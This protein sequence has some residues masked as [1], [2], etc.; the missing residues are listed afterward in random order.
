MEIIP[1]IRDMGRTLE[2]AEEYGAVFEYDDFMLGEQI[3]QAEECRRRVDY[4]K[5][6]DRDRSMDT[7]HGLFLDV[8]VHS[9][10]RLIREVSEKRVYQSMQIAEE[11]GV[12]GVVFHSGLISNFHVKSYRSM[13]LEKN[14]AFWKRVLRDFPETRIYMENMFDGEAD[15]IVKLAEAMEDERF[16]ICLDYAHASAYSTGDGVDDWFHK[17]ERFLKHMHINDNNLE[18]DLH[19][20]VG[21][22][23]IDWQVFR[24]LV[25]NSSFAPSILIEASG[26]EAQ[27]KSLEYLKG[28]GFLE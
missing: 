7:L 14:L 18:D 15:D 4:Y 28:I 20:P 19:L 11:L 23:R 17:T 10:D 9:Q 16:G 2:L 8:V 26:Y 1:D 22:G 13:W 21:D 24:E 25:E 6:L 5:G 27:K 12:R 3:D